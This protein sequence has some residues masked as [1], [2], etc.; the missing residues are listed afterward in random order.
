MGSLGNTALIGGDLPLSTYR[1]CPVVWVTRNLPQLLTALKMLAFRQERS[2]C[3][4]IELNTSATHKYV[5]K[6]V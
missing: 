3:K 6:G 1:T 5:S 4:H 2:T